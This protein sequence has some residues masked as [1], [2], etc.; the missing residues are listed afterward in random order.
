LFTAAI[1]AQPSKERSSDGTDQELHFDED[2]PFAWADSE[3]GASAAS[4]PSIAAD[5]V[6]ASLLHGLSRVSIQG[7]G[8]AGIRSPEAGRGQSMYTGAVS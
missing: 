4:A 2:L 6:G 5:S 1:P 8:T 3:G 7:G